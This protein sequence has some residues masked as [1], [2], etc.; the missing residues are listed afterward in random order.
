MSSAQAIRLV[1]NVLRR[2]DDEGRA[3]AGAAQLGEVADIDG[4]LAAHGEVLDHRLDGIAFDIFD[5]LIGAIGREV[6]TGPARQQG[7]LAGLVDMCRIV[8]EQIIRLAACRSHDHGRAG[9]QADV[10][11]IAAVGFAASLISRT[12]RARMGLVCPLRK[13]AS[14]CWAA[15]ARPRFDVPA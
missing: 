8:F 12:A 13:I 7:E 5:R 10:I 11:G 2:A 6:D 1:G 9:E 3:C 14:A 4:T 15:K